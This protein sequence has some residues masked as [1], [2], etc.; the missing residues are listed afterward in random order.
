MLRLLRSAG[1]QVVLAWVLGAYLHLALRSTRWTL[2]GGEHLDGH[3]DGSPVIAGFWHECLPLL[4]AL[5]PILLRR[6]ATG[7]PSVLIS[8]HRD[9][10][11]IST[12]IRRFGVRIGKASVLR[13]DRI[14]RHRQIGKPLWEK[15][16]SGEEADPTVALQ[17]AKDAV[18]AEIKKTS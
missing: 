11:F 16:L 7:T 5:W 13:L 9:G 6:G 12:I 17:Q 3:L 8:K 2:I 4:P 18:V 14:V 10:R 15:F 1:V